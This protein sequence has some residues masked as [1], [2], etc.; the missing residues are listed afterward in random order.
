MLHNGKA[1][2][3]LALRSGK[4]PSVTN[5]KDRHPRL[6]PSKAKV[7]PGVITRPLLISVALGAKKKTRAITGLVF[8]KLIIIQ[9][10]VGQEVCPITQMVIIIIIITAATTTTTTVTTTTTRVICSGV[11]PRN[12]K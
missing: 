10:T 11:R 9:I 8:R 7:S 12:L 4:I 5:P 6:Q 2:Q 3:V 1:A